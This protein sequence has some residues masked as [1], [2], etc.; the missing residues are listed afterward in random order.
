MSIRHHCNPRSEVLKSDLTD[1]IFAADFGDLV[2]GTAPEV[3]QNPALFFQNTHPAKQLCKVIQVIFERLADPAEGGATI[4]LSTGFG[5]GKTHTLMALWHLAQNISDPALGTELLPAAGRPRAVKV[6]AVDAGKVGAPVFRRHGRIQVR[7]LWGEIAF[8]L[9]GESAWRALGPA[10][11][12]EC[13]PD[14]D[15]LGQLFP[16]GPVLILLDELVIYMA[17]LSDRGQGNLLAFLNKL[18]SIV[19]RRPQT[20]LVV[21]D[22]SDQR[23]YARES[24]KVEDALISAAVKL[25]D[26]LGRKVSDFDPIGDEAAKVIIRRLFASVDPSAAQK[27][28]AVYHNLYERVLG[29]YPG[30]LPPEAASAAYAKRIVECYPFH[31]RL[32]DTA[33]GRL[34]ALQ[35]FNKSRGTLRLFA[36]ILRDIWDSEQDLDLITAGDLNWSSPRIQGDLL[37]R[38]NRDSFKAAIT[39]DIERHAAELDGGSE[40]VHR[41]V[42]SALLLES[43]PLQSNSGMTPQDL[44]LAVLRPDEAG[45]EPSEAMERLMGTCWHT[46]S[47]PGGHG[48][49]FRYEPNVNRLIEE[50][51]GDVLLEDAKSRVFAEVQG[52][53]SGPAFRL[54]PWPKKAGH[55]AESAELQLVL[56]ENEDMARSVCAFCDDSNP[57]AP[58]PRR[59]QNAIVAVAP[60]ASALDAAVERARRLLAAEAIERDNRTGE[61]GKLIREQLQRLKPELQKQ[62]RIQACRAFNRVVIAAGGSKGGGKSQ[63]SSYELEE[64]FQVPEDKILQHAQGQACLRKFLDEK[65]LIYQPGNALDV[66]RFLRDVLPGATPL[67]DKPEVYT[68]KA[69]HERFLSARGLRLL[70]NGEVVRETLKRGVSEGKLVVQLP[71]GRA[72][73]QNGFVEGSEGRRRRFPGTLAGFQLSDE[74]LVTTV[75]SEYGAAITKEDADDGG[76][77]T[78]S[79]PPPPPHEGRTIASDWEKAIEL[80]SER[81]LL[82]LH[83]IAASPDAASSLAML[84][85]P[86]GANTLSLSVTVTGEV[87][88]GGHMNFAANDIKPTHPAKPLEIARTIFASL[89]TGASNYQVDL[90]LRFGSTG[91]DNMEAALRRAASD[92]SPSG[93]SVQAVFDK[94]HGGSR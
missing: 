32:L 55:A 30:L 63:I 59:F 33:Q 53:F 64:Q 15:L 93:V 91:R 86:F 58:I 34:G 24:A 17:T 47:M 62:F 65:G 50:R 38:L 85:Q 36:R 26:V 92:A 67:P 70:P 79:L 60:S 14:E 7:S 89:S 29:E 20:V 43:L 56:C 12:P 57:S 66:G 5:G 61:S 73:D 88:D 2:A 16:E 8:G 39:V 75:R 23:A 68:A 41:R 72:Y 42:L 46:Y 82:E 54:V 78:V 74:V 80:A 4:R 51:A 48:W 94:P 31:P 35:E 37:Q 22:P 18:T 1:A 81:P 77:G 52:Y 25:D 44:T 45:P 40:G 90:R 69:I 6:V 21:T 19:G 71:N 9:G 87:R 10:D 84:A 49:Q 27:A 76:G 13:Q 28:S 3:Y 83:L 11:D